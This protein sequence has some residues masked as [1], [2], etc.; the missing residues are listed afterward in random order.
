MTQDIKTQVVLYD[1]KEI[2]RYLETMNSN[3]SFTV[4]DLIYYPYM[5]FEHSFERK[6]PLSPLK[7]NIGS[8]IDAVSGIAAMVDKTPV[9]ITD[10]IALEKIIPIQLDQEKAKVLADDH[11][12]RV[13]SS[14]IKVLMTP[15]VEL[16]HNVL[17]Y[18]PY[19][20]VEG[21][22]KHKKPFSLVVDSI[23]GKF[24]PL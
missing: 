24:H 4:K 10:S 3:S 13:I 5:F 19:W 6:N 21:K 15:K 20:I 23:S 22:R 11:L 1:E 2:I 16:L 18:R 17:F 12:F 8:T 14:K 7:G 9:F